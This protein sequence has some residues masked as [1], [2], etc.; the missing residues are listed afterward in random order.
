MF[1][2]IINLLKGSRQKK[3]EFN[4]KGY[5]GRSK[6]EKWTLGAEGSTRDVPRI[7]GHARTRA[8]MKLAKKTKVKTN[9]DG[10]KSYLLHR[11]MSENEHGNSVK[12]NS[13]EHDKNT[14]WSPHPHVAHTWGYKYKG[15]ATSA[16]VHENDIHHV[17]QQIGLKGKG[18]KIGESKYKNE[19]EVIVNPHKSVI[20]DTYKVESHYHPK[21]QFSLNESISRKQTTKKR[22]DIAKAKN[23]P[24]G[25]IRKRKDGTYVKES[26]GQWRKMGKPKPVSRW[27]SQIAKIHASEKTEMEK[28]AWVAGQFAKAG[29]PIGHLLYASRE[30]IGRG[31]NL[32]AIDNK[33]FKGLCKAIIEKAYESGPKGF[34]METIKRFEK[35]F[36]TWF[37]KVAQPKITRH[38]PLY[39]ALG[40]INDD[41]FYKKHP[42]WFLY[43]CSR[44]AMHNEGM[45]DMSAVKPYMK[46]AIRKYNGKVPETIRKSRY[47]YKA[48]KTI[49]HIK[50][51]KDMI[52]KP[53]HKHLIHE[54]S[55]ENKKQI[56][57]NGFKASKNKHVMP[58]VYTQ[59][60][61]SYRSTG[62]ESKIKIK[63]HEKTKVANLGTERPMDHLR[64]F[65]SNEYHHAYHHILKNMGYKVND[66]HA[67][68][69]PSKYYDDNKEHIEHV[70]KKNRQA[71]HK[72]LVD[73][74]KHNGVDVVKNAG[75]HIIVN[76]KCIKGME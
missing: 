27:E 10:T 71:F 73:T 23:F 41:D 26:S 25:T 63:T 42:K 72:H 20:N 45:V 1:R 34:E 38:V 60:N 69:N 36:N 24:I 30:I 32:N 67:G 52:E 43:C 58:G 47:I 3:L 22:M 5:R 53:D 40:K 19:H 6:I 59:P 14:S 49:K 11:G 74:M 48:E 44:L 8:L 9:E 61:H 65:G 29:K 28:D 50:L 33:G 64:G 21:K 13:V 75:E 18:N 35:A 62:E 12:K 31:A 57:K 37:E 51:H 56:L 2:Y 54:T 66:R 4:P 39:K 7:K 70:V 46:N 55:E 15:H 68:K 76:K 16:W 17:P